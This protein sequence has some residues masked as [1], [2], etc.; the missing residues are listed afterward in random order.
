MDNEEDI[1]WSHNEDMYEE[2]M[3][4]YVGTQEEKHEMATRP[5]RE[6]IGCLSWLAALGTLAFATTSLARFGNNPGRTHWEATKRVLPY[7]KGTSGWRL[8]LGGDYDQPDAYTDADWGS[9][10]DDR[11]STGAY[12]VKVGC[13]EEQDTGHN[14]FTED[15]MHPAHNITYRCNQYPLGRSIEHS[16]RSTEFAFS[17]SVSSTY[18]HCKLGHAPIRKLLVTLRCAG[19]SSLP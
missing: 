16:T 1:T 19:C 2:T 8:K 6:L 7:L 3:P 5:Y 12:I 4:D 9:D 15:M 11:R 18:T 17:C 10:R 13:G 14:S